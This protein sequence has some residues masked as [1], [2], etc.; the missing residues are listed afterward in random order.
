[1]GTVNDEHIDILL[2]FMNDEIEEGGDRPAT[3]FFDFNLGTGKD[4]LRFQEES[5]L[6][7]DDIQRALKASYARD[8]IEH[9]FCGGG[10]IFRLTPEGQ[11]RAISVE[12]AKHY[13]PKP[14]QPA[15]SIGAIHGP[16]QIGNQNIQNIDVVFRYVAAAIDGSGAP[17]QEKEEAKSLWRKALAH[18]ITA[19]II[20]AGAGAIFNTL[21]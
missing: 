20:G 6:I 2:C 7:D 3:V 18:P 8:Y 10:D 21:S 5:G 12:K 9:P 11:G 15:I 14:E 17:A 13:V 19:A 1:M 4:L 16:A